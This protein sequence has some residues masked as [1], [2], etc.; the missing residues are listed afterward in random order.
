MGRIETIDQVNAL[1]RS[2]NEEWFATDL[3]T[4]ALGAQGQKWTF[5]ISINT[6]T[7]VQYTLDSGTTWIA[8]NAGADLVADAGYEFTFIVDG[9]AIYVRCT[10]SCS[11]FP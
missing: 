4:S 1:V 2:A 6:T 3:D 8:F 9:D 5:H 10:P 11:P 7:L